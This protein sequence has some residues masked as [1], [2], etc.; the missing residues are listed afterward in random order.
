MLTLLL[1]SCEVNTSGNINIE[2]NDIKIIKKN[3][4]CFGLFPSRKSFSLDTTGL[5]LTYIP[6][7]NIYSMRSMDS[8]ASELNSDSLEAYELA[9][10]RNALL[11]SD[12]HRKKAASLLGIGE[13][14]LYRK[15]NKYDIE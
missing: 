14:T 2:P 12:G 1:S 13:A 5:G 10:I 9:A 3:N 4:L 8:A 6:C 11:K 15:L 7:E